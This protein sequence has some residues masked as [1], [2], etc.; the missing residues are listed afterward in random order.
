MSHRKRN[1]NIQH[2]VVGACGHRGEKLVRKRSKSAALVDS[3]GDRSQ[4][5]KFSAFRVDDGVVKTK[6]N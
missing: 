6:T 4:L 1:Q 3:N 2:L 5:E